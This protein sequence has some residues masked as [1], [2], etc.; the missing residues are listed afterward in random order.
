[1]ICDA[2]ENFTFYET[3]HIINGYN[4]SIYNY[5]LAMPNLFYNPV[6]NSSI[7]AH[8]LRGLTFVFNSDGTLY[9]RFLL[10]NKFFNLN[11][12]DCSSYGI[13]KNKKIIDITFKEDG[14]LLSFIELPD[15]KIVAKTKASFEAYQAEKAQNIFETNVAINKLVNWC[16]DNDIVP[17]F[18]YVSPT[19]RVVLVYEKTDLVLTKLRN[20]I[21]GE[22]IPIKS[23]PADLLEGIT[24][25]KS[26]SNLT[27]DE[28]VEKCETEIGYEGFVVQ[29]EDDQMIK[30]KLFDYIALHNLHTE[31]L[32]REDYIIDLVINEKI[33]DILSQ[34]EEGDERK[35]MVY[36]IIDLIDR[37][38][39]RISNE[40]NNLIIKYNGSKKDFAINYRKHPYFFIAIKVINGED[41]I[42]VIKKIILKD[43]Y[44]LNNAR[45]WINNEKLY[46]QN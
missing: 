8:E 30:L 20:N 21:T 24:I 46:K 43:T 38:I 25:V 12:S 35:T 10:L 33:D 28:L 14:S 1:M 2:N 37:H 36:E 7:T 32:H 17:I 31:E 5:R 41:L 27:L 9:N 15:K 34:L 39:K 40:T 16:I 23:L 11:Q 26:F 18:E 4:I 45:N 29:F 42:S 6:P 19:N 3:K 44:F 22:Y 13:V